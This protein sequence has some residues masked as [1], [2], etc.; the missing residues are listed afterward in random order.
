MTIMGASHKRTICEV[1]REIYEL[2]PKDKDIDLQVKTK[3]I[4]AEEMAKKMSAKMI[5]YN[6][7]VFADFWEDNLDYE[8]DMIRR[9]TTQ[10]KQM[11]QRYK[12]IRKKI[13]NAK[14]KKKRV[15]KKSK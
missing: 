15:I 3:L 11:M 5:E 9:M 1:L 10:Y 13:T 7:D 4:E 12:T 2:H 14:R 6:K 8:A